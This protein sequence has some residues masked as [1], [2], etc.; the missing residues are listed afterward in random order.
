MKVVTTKSDSEVVVNENVLS[1]SE[2]TS[3]VIAQPVFPVHQLTP[4]FRSRPSAT[5]STTITPFLLIHY[6]LPLEV[7]VCVCVCHMFSVL[8]SFYVHVLDMYNILFAVCYD[9]HVLFEH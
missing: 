3:C 1:C 6:S 7:A 5:T 8:S 2:M 4:Q 9:V